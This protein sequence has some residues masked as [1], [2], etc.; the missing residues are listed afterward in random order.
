MSDSFISTAYRLIVDL[1]IAAGTVALISFWIAGFAR[2]RRG[3]HVRSGKV[4]L[5]AMR[6]I[7]ITAVPMALMAYLRGNPAQGTFLLYLVVLVA[8]T[9][10]IA[11]RAVRLKQDFAA[12]RGGSYRF[13]AYA[14]PLAALA[15]FSFG[16]VH[17]VPLLWGFS[18]VGLFVG[19]GMQRTLRAA[20]PEPGWWLKRHYGAML[21][22]GVGTHVAF[23]S[24][25][26]SR[27]LP[28]AYAGSVQNLAWFGPLSVALLVLLVLNRRH[29]R[30]FGTAGHQTQRVSA[31]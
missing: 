21:G 30:R 11:P 1:H 29:Q 31:A 2:K 26:L 19:F 14:L 16:I 9:V 3:L 25:G 6:A 27:S 23:L 22:N 24:V 17:G 12:F 7:L 4:Y 8:T 15:A 13:F 5:A 10:S 18:L 20:Q 28:A